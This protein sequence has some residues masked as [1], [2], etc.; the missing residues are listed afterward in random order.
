MEMRNNDDYLRLSPI[1]ARQAALFTLEIA[2]Q[3][4]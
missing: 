4:P 3:L 1:A 2:R